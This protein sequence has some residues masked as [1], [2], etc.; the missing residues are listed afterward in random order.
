M[1]LACFF[2]DKIDVIRL[3]I[4]VTEPPYVPVREGANFD[5]FAVVSEENVRKLIVK[6]KT[7]SCALHPMPKKIG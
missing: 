1:N 6:L 3:T 4:G 7:T 2:N 5:T